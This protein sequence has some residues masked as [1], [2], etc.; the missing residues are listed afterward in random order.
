MPGDDANRR[1]RQQASQ[2]AARVLVARA[3]DAVAGARE[4]VHLVSVRSRDLAA[5]NAALRRR[6]ATSD[7]GAPRPGTW[8]P[9]DGV[10][11]SLRR[12]PDGWCAG[13]PDR[14]PAQ[15]VPRHW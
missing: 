4:H 14:A 8:G 6:L 10:A 9:R 12:V 15:R 2:Q 11:G 13:P 5:S 1:A 3:L 7:L